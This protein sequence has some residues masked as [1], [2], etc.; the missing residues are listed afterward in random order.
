MIIIEDNETGVIEPTDKNEIIKY[1]I[2]NR[3]NIYF[4][5]AGK[6]LLKKQQNGQTGVGKK[7]RYVSPAQ[8]FVHKSTGNILLSGWQWGGGSNSITTDRGL[9]GRKWKTTKGGKPHWKEFLID[10]MSEVQLR[11]D[12]KGN[13]E[14]FTT[15]GDKAGTGASSNPINLNSPQPG[16]YRKDGGNQ[17]AS[18]VSDYVNVND[19][20]KTIKPTATPLEPEIEPEIEPTV[21]TEPEVPIKPL[22]KPEIVPTTPNVKPA[23]TAPTQNNQN[24]PPAEMTEPEE[25]EPELENPLGDND[26]WKEEDLTESFKNKS[27]FLKWILNIDYGSK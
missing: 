3:I 20:L 13:Y 22:N 1:A 14:H 2:K 12:G 5:Y 4:R 27:G 7:L 10:E 18:S 15:P 9:S 25:Y 24:V 16:K 23:A 17:H 11:Q 19:P 8:L 6:D 21:P 26:E